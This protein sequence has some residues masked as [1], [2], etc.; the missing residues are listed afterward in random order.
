M[1]GSSH[2]T[3]Q[4]HIYPHKHRMAFST[5]GSHSKHHRVCDLNKAFDKGAPPPLSLWLA[6]GGSYVGIAFF[7]EK[8]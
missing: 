8:N 7:Q 3:P 6:L 1:N 5:G 4:K 2:N